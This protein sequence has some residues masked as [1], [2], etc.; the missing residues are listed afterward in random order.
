VPAATTNSRHQSRPA[1][2]GA[3]LVLRTQDVYWPA[4]LCSIVRSPNCR[5]LHSST[6]SRPTC[7]STRQCWLQLWV[8]CTVVRCCRDCTASMA[9]TTNVQTQLDCDMNLPGLEERLGPVGCLEPKHMLLLDVVCGSSC[10]SVV[11]TDG[12]CRRAE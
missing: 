11:H 7:S 5:F 6:S 8:S 10:Q 4:Q 9:P 12:I 1:V 2:S 3:L